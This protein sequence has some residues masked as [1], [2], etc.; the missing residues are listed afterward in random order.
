[1]LN[2]NPNQRYFT[3]GSALFVT[4]GLITP[5][6][7]PADQRA[8]LPWMGAIGN[9]ET[10]Y[11]GVP[12][13]F[14]EQVECSLPEPFLGTPFLISQTAIQNQRSSMTSGLPFGAHHNGT[15]NVDPSRHLVIPG[16]VGKRYVFRSSIYC[17][18]RRLRANSSNEVPMRSGFRAHHSFRILR[19][20][21]FG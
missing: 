7:A 11:Y 15:L 17:M 21:L 6:M 16:L 1:M 20:P 4:A 5:T 9:S 8:R 10:P 3:R 19:Y 14:K 2:F 18:I 13:T 12:Y